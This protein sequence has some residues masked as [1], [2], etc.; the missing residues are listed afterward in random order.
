MESAILRRR[1]E[2]ILNPKKASIE[3]SSVDASEDGDDPPRYTVDLSLPPRK[4]YQHIVVDFKSQI[5]TLPVL[6]DE[7]VKDLRANAPVERVR[8][9]SRLLLRRVYNKEEN[10]EL[11]GIQE[12]TGI[13]MYLLV[14]FNVLLD[15]FMGCTSGAVRVK[16][17]DKNTKMLHFRTLD[18]GMNALREVI[19]HLDFVE[20]PGGDVIAS[21][22]TYV[23]YVGVL[24]GVRKGLSLSLNFRPNHDDSGRLSN[25]R[26]YFHHLLVLL[27]FQPSISSLLRGYL[28]PN[29]SSNTSRTNAP[30]LDSIKRDLPNFKTTAAYLIFSDGDDTLTIEKD[31]Q[32]AVI[33]SANDFIVATNHDLAAESTTQSLKATHKDS[34]KTLLD[35]IVVESI[36]RRNTAVKLW[37]KSME[38]AKRNS[39]KKP[40]THEQDLTKNSIIRWMDT[41]P[42]LNE[43]THFATVMDPKDG[44][45]VWIKRYIEAVEDN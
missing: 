5:A 44:K 38:R 23:G 31:H 4:R 43:E 18:W 14:A 6:F 32:T 19:V 11:R 16:D 39:S 3:D 17:D 34:F 42:I 27:G 20:K 7:V 2:R 12:A 10:E 8:W 1:N 29:L 13:E 36:D 37:E 15:L 30:A 25:F 21:S 33:R 26:F 41:Y 35:G 24:T 22:I 9:L 40:R 28:L 45:V